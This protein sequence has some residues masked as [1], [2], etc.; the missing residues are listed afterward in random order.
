MCFDVFKLKM[1]YFFFFAVPLHIKRWQHWQESEYLINPRGYYVITAS[2]C[3]VIGHS[4]SKFN[5]IS[6]I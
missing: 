6:L 3:T 2:D 4:W 5:K 1:Y